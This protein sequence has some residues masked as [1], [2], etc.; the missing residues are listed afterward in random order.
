MTGA[1]V[2][3]LLLTSCLGVPKRK[4]LTVAQLRDL[5]TRVRGNLPVV[6]DRELEM[7]DLL[8]IGCDR[9]MASRILELLSQTELLHWYVQLGQRENCI[10][11]TRVSEC[12]P[13]RLRTVLGAEATGVFW[14]KGDL[15][16]LQNKTISLVGS[17]DLYPANKA[18]AA[19]VGKQAAFQG[20]TLVSGN[21][22]GADQIAQSSC[23]LHGGSVISVV[24]DK[25]MSHQARENVLYISEDG[26][27]LDFSTVRALKRNR[28]IHALSEQVFVAQCNL[29]KGGTW[30]GTKN[31]L[32]YR[33][34]DVFCFDDDSEA[35]KELEQMG[36]SC[37][38]MEDLKN[39][40]AI[41]TGSTNFLD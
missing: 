41:D 40:S 25:L 14:C 23:L 11:V 30:D 37:I 6:P 10:P 4:P 24:A 29:G 35:S 38:G 7:S 32:R 27:D 5:T 36:A 39:F 8:A 2:G 9:A 12:Y 34:S 21:A 15:R 13:Q 18:F 33:W 16:L 1:E 31:N 28:V 26:F 17:R 20:Y 19:E 3:Y 22:R